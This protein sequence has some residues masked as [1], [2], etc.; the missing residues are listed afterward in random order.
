VFAVTGQASAITFVDESNERRIYA[1]IAG[2]NG[3]LML[4]HFNG[5]SWHWID[6]GVPEGA[7]SVRAPKALTYVDNAGNRRIYVFVLAQGPVFQR[8]ALHFWNGFQWQWVNQGAPSPPFDPAH[9]YSLSALTFVDWQG[10]RQIHAYGM[11]DDYAS[12]FDKPTHLVV[13]Y[14]G[15]FNWNWADLNAGENDCTS[16]FSA[17]TAVT[18]LDSNSLRRIDVFCVHGGLYRHSLIGGNWSTASLGG[19]PSFYGPMSSVAY[20]ASDKDHVRVYMRSENRKAVLENHNGTWNSLGAPLQRPSPDVH[21]ISAI[22]YLDNTSIRKTLV[23]AQFGNRLFLKSSNGLAWG[24]WTDQ[25]LPPSSFYSG[26]SDPSALTYFD[27]RSGTQRIHVF[28]TGSF[29]RMYVNYWDGSS[30]KWLDHGTP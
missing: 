5:T 17:T 28:T 19:T 30:W 8:L 24:S 21:G 7:S 1:F 11:M 23:F 25:G 4:N 6:Q 10:N 2:D 27:S 16:S 29:D 13:N 14:W 22:T 15:G 9:L 20:D 26:V 18:Y 3:H 12:G